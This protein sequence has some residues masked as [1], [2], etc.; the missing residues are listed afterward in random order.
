M[1]PR[2][3]SPFRSRGTRVS[4]YMHGCTYL[5]SN[6]RGA[7][8][9]KPASSHTWVEA[10]GCVLSPHLTPLT[11]LNLPK[12]PIWINLVGK[13]E[14]VQGATR[15]RV[16]HCMLVRSSF[17]ASDRQNVLLI[18]LSEDDSEEWCIKPTIR[19]SW[20][21]LSLWLGVTQMFANQRSSIGFRS[22]VL[23]VK[24]PTQAMLDWRKKCSY[25]TGLTILH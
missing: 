11:V 17:L 21:T 10:G 5:T 9:Q 18:D 15:R 19:P 12:S 6:K 7:G 13:T 3:F 20:L 1:V 16:V 25:A 8:V 4:T 24:V 23:R 2:V 22:G 14:S